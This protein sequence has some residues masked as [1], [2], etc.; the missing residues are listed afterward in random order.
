MRAGYERSLDDCGVDFV[1]GHPPF[2]FSFN[3]IESLGLARLPWR[4][5]RFHA[6]DFLGV[7]GCY[8]FAEF[9]FLA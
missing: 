3:T 5:A 4:S 7:Q 1:V 2:T 9:A 6:H 8:S